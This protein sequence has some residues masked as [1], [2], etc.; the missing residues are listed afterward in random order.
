VTVFWIF[1]LARLPLSCHSL[2]L[3]TNLSAAADTW[4][5]LATSPLPRNAAPRGPAE[6]DEVP[7]NQT[8]EERGR[9][10]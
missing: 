9:R 3:G 4:A 7:V 10:A 1:W 6:E 5:K 8:F 2:L